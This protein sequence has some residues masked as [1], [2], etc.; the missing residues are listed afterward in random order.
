MSRTET[1]MFRDLHA[2]KI[3]MENGKLEAKQWVMTPLGVGLLVG[4]ALLHPQ[5]LQP[6]ARPMNVV[7]SGKSLSFRF[8]EVRACNFFEFCFQSSGF[9]QVPWVFVGILSAITAWGIHIGEGW[10]VLPPW[11]AMVGATFANWKR[12]MK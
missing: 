5:L 4:I 10:W 6:Y 9:G 3:K 11:V 8:D 7:V 12:W 2:A 1:E